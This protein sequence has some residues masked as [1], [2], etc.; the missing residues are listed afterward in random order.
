MWPFVTSISIDRLRQATNSGWAR[1]A[2]LLAQ[3]GMD[4]LLGERAMQEGERVMQE[5]WVDLTA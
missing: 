2:G 3:S 4:S 1:H 5:V